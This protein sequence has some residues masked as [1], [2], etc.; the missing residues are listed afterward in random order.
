MTPDIVT[1]IINRR[2]VRPYKTADEISDL[3]ADKTI[4]DRLS[5]KS[6]IFQIQVTATVND[7]PVKITAVYN[8]SMRALFYWSEE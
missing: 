8:R 5:T 7:V 3:I 4:L 2:Q 6:S 1:E